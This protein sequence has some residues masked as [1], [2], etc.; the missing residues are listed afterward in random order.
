M[1]K[2]DYC[3]FS[4]INLND[5]F[6]DS[7]KNDYTEFED[8]FNRKSLYGEKAFI[9]TVDNNLEGFLYLKIENGPITDVSPEIYV[10]RAI[11]IGTFKINPHGT[12]L[13]ERFI[14]K[15]IDFAISEKIDT[16]YVTIFSHHEYLLDM[17][18][19]F[20]FIIHGTKETPNGTEN[21]LIKNLKNI[22]NNIFLDYPLVNSNSDC[23]LLA[24]KPQYHT[25]LFPDSKLYNEKFDVIKDISHTN[26]ITKIYI[27][28]MPGMSN[29][30]PGDNILIYR[31][32]DGQGSAF[33]R[34]VATTLCVVEDCK[35]IRHFANFA[36][37]KTYCKNYSIFD[38][39]ELNSFLESRKPYYVIKMTYN[40]SFPRR[41]IRGKLINEVG[42]DG[43]RYFGCFPLTNNEFN[44][45]IELGEVNESYIIN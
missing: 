38:D 18:L 22:K 37:L 29:I 31:T 4:N 11:K 6:F 45:I 9:Q 40:I 10:D 7:L 27:A 36:E 25:D 2:F 14:K 26:S 1:E 42:I 24:I 17:F 15:S 28:K 23:H 21:V 20:G 43:K 12:R 3:N 34:A 19:K 41:I 33:F 16:L 35:S 39:S 32:G 44:S 5:V 30:K 13:G 8:W